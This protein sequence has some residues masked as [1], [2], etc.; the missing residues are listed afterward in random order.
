MYCLKCKGRTE[1]VNV[2]VTVTRNNRKRMTASCKVCGRTKSRFVA[3]KSGQGVFNDVLAKLGSELHLPASR[4]E[5]HQADHLTI[6]ASIL[7]A[8]RVL[9]TSREAGKAIGE[10]T[11]W[12]ECV[13]CTISSI[14]Q[15]PIPPVET[16]A[17]KP[18]L[19]E[20]SRLL[21]MRGLTAFRET[22][23]A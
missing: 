15:T 16:S 23:L 11:S 13:N 7:T 12:T 10:L 18:W 6:K 4:G 1:S 22:W 8:A 17:T 20:H 2:Q 9:S 21:R 14:Q 5:Q 3:N 19:T